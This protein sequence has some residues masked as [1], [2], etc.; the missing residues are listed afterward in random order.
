MKY[1]IFILLSFFIISAPA[2]AKKS[3][4]KPA[5]PPA[6]TSP[7]AER[8]NLLSEDDKRKFD[9]LSDDQKEKIRKGQIDEGFNEW[10]VELA[11]GKPFYA[12]EHHPKFVDYEQ[13]WL[14][15][16]PEVTQDVTENQ[17]FDR[18]TNWPT[19]HRVTHKKTCNV[20]DFFVLWDRGVVQEVRHEPAPQVH[21]SCT[22]ETQEAFLPIVNGK[23]VEPK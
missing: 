2:F 20:S 3:K 17:I 5:P 12:T 11:L 7:A 22:I 9:A 16:K 8:L 13:V 10:M 14:Y 4:N 23:P 18:Q 1:F 15:T 6:V 21:G 19:I